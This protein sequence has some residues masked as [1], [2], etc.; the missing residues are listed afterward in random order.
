[1]LLPHYKTILETQVNTSVVLYLDP[2]L[3]EAVLDSLLRHLAPQTAS[4]Y[5]YTFR[6]F[7]TFLCAATG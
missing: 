7:R 4:R 2:L 1:M 5:G 6:K 3:D